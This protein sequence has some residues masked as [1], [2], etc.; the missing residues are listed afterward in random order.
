MMQY[1]LA[2]VIGFLL[3][4]SSIVY[5]TGGNAYVNIKRQGATTFTPEL[6]TNHTTG[7]SSSGVVHCTVT[8]WID[9]PSRTSKNVTAYNDASAV[10]P[11]MGPFD[12]ASLEDYDPAGT[13]I[14]DT[15]N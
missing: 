2:P 13:P 10:V 12:G 1:V 15:A 3:A 6:V 9:F 14:I 4:F 11:L 8:V 7:C 5:A